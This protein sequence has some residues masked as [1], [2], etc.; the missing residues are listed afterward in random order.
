MCRN[1]NKLQAAST[2]PQIQLLFSACTNICRSKCYLEWDSCFFVLLSDTS[3]SPQQLCGR[4]ESVIYQI[5]LSPSTLRLL[6]IED[7]LIFF[8]EIRIVWNYLKI[9]F[10]RPPI[11]RPITCIVDIGIQSNLIWFIPESTL[12][13]TGRST[14][15]RRV[16]ADVE[17]LHQ[18]SKLPVLLSRRQLYGDDFVDCVPVIKYINF[19][20]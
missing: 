19:Q 14:A 5:R 20:K 11:I 18:V 12:A 7:T 4:F 8:G 9:L 17:L 15:F 1:L 2:P 6:H 10:C 3:S 16:T 13:C